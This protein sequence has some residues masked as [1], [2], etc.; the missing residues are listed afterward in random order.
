VAAGGAGDQAAEDE[1]QKQSASTLALKW[2][3]LAVALGLI[4]S[5]LIGIWMGTTQIR[6]KGLAWTLLLVGALVPIGLLAI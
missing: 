1:D 2:F 3:L 6:R 5:T 4:T